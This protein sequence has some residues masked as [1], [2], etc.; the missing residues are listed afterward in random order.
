M[1]EDELA[2]ANCQLK[3]L[4]TQDGLTGLANRRSFDEVFDREW[5]RAMRE[6]TPLG[7][8]MLDVDK[9]KVLRPADG[10]VT[11]LSVTST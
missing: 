4:A 8:I 6:K 11:A 2:A 3:T 1:L 7:L 9:F 5:L 10:L